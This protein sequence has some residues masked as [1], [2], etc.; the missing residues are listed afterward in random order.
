VAHVAQ[1]TER[2]ALQ[3]ERVISNELFEFRERD[4]QVPEEGD[5]VVHRAS[6]R[7][8][9]MGFQGRAPAVAVRLT[10]VVTS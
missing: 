6:A 5:L 9:D 3:Q 10:I 2:I 7:P 8:W 1:L 4:V